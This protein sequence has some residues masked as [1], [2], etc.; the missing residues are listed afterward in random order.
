MRKKRRIYITEFDYKRLER[1][2]EMLEDTGSRD[3][4]HIERLDEELRKAEI[5]DPKN[6]PP[7]VITM[8]S[9]VR[10]QNLESRESSIYHLVFPG[11]ADPKQNRV[12]ILAPVGVALIG[13]RIGDIIE[14]EVPAGI[15]KM[16][17]EEIVYQPEASGDYHL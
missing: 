6:V 4:R 14:W 8:N 16:K 1:L 13:Y 10:V 17:I 2:I 12:S 5:V 7:D 3:R 11:E 9:K 15:R